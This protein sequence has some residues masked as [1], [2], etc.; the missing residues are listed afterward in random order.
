MKQFL[1]VGR[2]NIK[3]TLFNDY[4]NSKVTS[5]NNSSNIL[6]D[7]FNWVYGSRQFEPK[8]ADNKQSQNYIPDQFILNDCALLLSYIALFEI[9]Q[10][11]QTKPVFHLVRDNNDTTMSLPLRLNDK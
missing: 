2:S 3:M 4:N 10:N 8:L 7:K 6:A 1:Y 5:L 9:E 11:T